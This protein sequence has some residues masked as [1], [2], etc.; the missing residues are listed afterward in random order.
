MH[1][2]VLIF[3]HRQRNVTYLRCGGLKASFPFWGKDVS[4]LSWK[5]GAV[6]GAEVQS[7]LRVDHDIWWMEVV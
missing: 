7:G 5:L 6:W 4:T 2:T 3:S 1:S